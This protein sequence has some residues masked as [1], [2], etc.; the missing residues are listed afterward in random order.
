L[1]P[2]RLATNIP[3]GEIYHIPQLPHQALA[4][5]MVILVRMFGMRKKPSQAQ[6]AIFKR[7]WLLK[8][9]LNIET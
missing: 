3:C 8:L 5:L 6:L 7:R 4:M 2:W 9:S 1:E